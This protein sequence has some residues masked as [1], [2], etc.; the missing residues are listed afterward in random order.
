MSPD[1]A[2]GIL[3]G[4]GGMWA[5]DHFAYPRIAHWWASVRRRRIPVRVR[6]R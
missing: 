5:L 4:A 6:D 3:L 1:L 2:I